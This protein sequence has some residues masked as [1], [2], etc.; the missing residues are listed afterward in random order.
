MQLGDRRR[1]RIPTTS[2]LVPEDEVTTLRLRGI[3]FDPMN[4]K[5]L[6][7]TRWSLWAIALRGAESR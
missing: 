6:T 2:Y 1:K 3:P 4:L 5:L 7:N